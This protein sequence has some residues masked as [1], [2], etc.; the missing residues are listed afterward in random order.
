MLSNTLG[1]HIDFQSPPRQLRQQVGCPSRTRQAKVSRRAVQAFQQEL[2]RGWGNDG[3]P[4]RARGFQQ[5]TPAVIEKTLQ[6][7]AHGI[8][9]LTRDASDLSH[10]MTIR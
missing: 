9:A 4:A 1:C 7:V 8:I 10:R 2:L 6:P 3:W 5:S